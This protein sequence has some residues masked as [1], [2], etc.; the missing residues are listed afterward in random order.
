[1]KTGRLI[2]VVGPSGVGK[3]TVMAGLVA[4]RPG[5]AVARR[6]ITRAVELGGEQFD[7]V[8]EEA[9]AQARDKGDFVLHWRAH[10]LSYGIPLS[11]TDTLG[12]GRDVLANVS[13]GVLKQADGLF[14][15]LQVLY[16]TASTDVLAARLAGRGRESVAGMAARLARPAEVMPPGLT[17]HTISN[18]GPVAA[19]VAAAL[20]ALYPESR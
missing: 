1:M 6:V 8:T 19:T 10:G 13:R 9:F 14:A 11:V 16:L 5:L 18:D 20:A 3:D 12:Q 15:G 2:A 7:G 17:V 4:A